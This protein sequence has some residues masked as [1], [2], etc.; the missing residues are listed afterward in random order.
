MRNFVRKT[1]WNGI[2]L[3]SSIKIARA[4][5]QIGATTANDRKVDLISISTMVERDQN[6]SF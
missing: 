6:T 3:E 4:G 5:Q 2:E 1:N